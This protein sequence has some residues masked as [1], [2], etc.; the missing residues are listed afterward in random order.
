M[1]NYKTIEG[2]KYLESKRIEVIAN[3]LKIDKIENKIIDYSDKYV[4]ELLDEN[5]VKY[6]CN[7]YG[8]NIEKF[9]EAFDKKE[10][11]KITATQKFLQDGFVV[12]SKVT[13]RN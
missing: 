1:K 8:S 7:Y 6:I 11:I 5:G 4:I 2:K 10:K 13:F 9:K 3:V 12:I